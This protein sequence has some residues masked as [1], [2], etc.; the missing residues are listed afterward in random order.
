M[1]LPGLTMGN[2]ASESATDAEAVR[3]ILETM[4]KTTKEF[5]E[6][7][8]QGQ[9]KE[10]QG[11][12]TRSYQHQDSYLEGDQVWY[13]Y[14]DANAWHGPAA[15]L[16]QRGNLVWIH[17]NGEIR[18][19]AVCRTKPYKLVKRMDPETKKVSEAEAMN[20]PEEVEK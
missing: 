7:E 10:C 3:M 1:T 2:V 11:I 9:F 8:M 5:R 14:K 4:N 17:N 19:V 12:R 16:C 20:E 13:Q 6:A 15:V 18:K